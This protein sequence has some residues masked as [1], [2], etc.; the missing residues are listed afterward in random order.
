ML[1]VAAAFSKERRV[2]QNKRSYTLSMCDFCIFYTRV[3]NILCVRNIGFNS[4][5][6]RILTQE[7]IIQYVCDLATRQCLYTGWL[8]IPNKDKA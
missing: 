7:M 8:K 3:L 6:F 4:I 1:F 2:F 5:Y